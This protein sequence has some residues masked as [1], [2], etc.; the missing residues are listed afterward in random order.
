M[1]TVVLQGIHCLLAALTGGLF[2]GA[3]VLGKRSADPY[4]ACQAMEHSP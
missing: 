4:P 1:S 2:H 3:L